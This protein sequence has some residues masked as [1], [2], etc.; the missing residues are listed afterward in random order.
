M[1]HKAGVSNACDAGRM[2][3]GEQ[4]FGTGNTLGAL[5]RDLQMVRDSLFV[6]VCDKGDQALYGIIFRVPC[7]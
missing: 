5:S 2:Y 6:P 4:R 7:S 1:E 3:V